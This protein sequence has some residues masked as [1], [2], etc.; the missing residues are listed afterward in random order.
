[1]RRS[2]PIGRLFSR[3]SMRPWRSTSPP[4]HAPSTTGASSC[5]HPHRHP[6]RLWHRLRTVPPR[7]RAK[8]RRLP[9]AARS[10]RNSRPRRK[11]KSPSPQAMLRPSR[12]FRP[13][14]QRRHP[15][16]QRPPPLP[17]L[18]PPRK[19]PRNPRQQGASRQ[20]S[21]NGVPAAP[22][23]RPHRPPPNRQP[24]KPRPRLPSQP[25][26]LRHLRRLHPRPISLPS[27]NGASRG[28]RVRKRSARGVRSS[29]KD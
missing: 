26:S 1:M 9:L 4:G 3:R 22:R 10:N 27:S 15:K 19:S 29:P 12:S 7:T 28:P 6:N 8:L 18:H 13:P 16:S 14:R 24:T 20:S 25:P 11:R 5:W 17:Q 23:A 2:A 21:A